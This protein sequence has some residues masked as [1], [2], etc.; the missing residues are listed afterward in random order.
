LKLNEIVTFYDKLLIIF[1]IL[2]SVFLLVLPFHFFHSGRNSD[3]ILKVQL[4]DQIVKTMSINENYDKDIVFSVTGP[5][6]THFIE[7]SQGRVR[8]KEAPEDDPL[9]ICE[10]TGWISQ[11]GPIIICV[12][13]NLSIWLEKS[14]SKLDGMSW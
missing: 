8:V 7:V 14:D 10:K 5:I 2:V 13:N 9:K 12:P 11:V 6:G 4:G 1:L 3:L